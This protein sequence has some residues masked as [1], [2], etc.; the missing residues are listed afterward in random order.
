[1]WRPLCRR[2]ASPHSDCGTLFSHLTSGKGTRAT[3]QAP[4]AALVFRGSQRVSGGDRSRWHAQA[5]TASR[6][7]HAETPCIN[8]H[9]ADRFTHVAS[10]SHSSRR[11]AHGTYDCSRRQVMASAM[12]QSP[13]GLGPL[14][15]PSVRR[16]GENCWPARR[17]HARVPIVQYTPMTPIPDASF[18]SHKH[19]LQDR[20]EP[21]TTLGVRSSASRRD[22]DLRRGLV[23][24]LF[25]L[26]DAM[27]VRGRSWS[28]F[29]G[30]R[31]E[32]ALKAGRGVER[33]EHHDAPP[34]PDDISAHELLGLAPGFSFA[35]PG[36]D[37]PASCIRI[38]G[39]PRRPPRAK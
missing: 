38:A 15:H 18:L 24:S 11:G 35:P 39:L 2:L 32:A 4:H 22:D 7:T 14:P 19:Q 28:D 1:M 34:L 21:S 8:D 31:L 3:R 10:V 17:W 33:A 23:F 26:P 25:V 13:W 20:S 37:L 27:R 9:S 6:T 5:R 36:C 29:Y 12:R 30:D 16:S